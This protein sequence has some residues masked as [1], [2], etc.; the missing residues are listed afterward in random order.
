[1]DLDNNQIRFEPCANE[2][3]ARNFILS[4]PITKDLYEYFKPF[5]Y[6]DFERG[7]PLLGE[8]YVWGRKDKKK[9]KPLLILQGKIGQPHLKVIAD[10]DVFHKQYP[11]KGYPLFEDWVDCQLRKFQSCII[12]GGCPPLCKTKAITLLNDEYR[13]DSNKCVGCMECIAHYDKGCLVTK[14]TQTRRT[15]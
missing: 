6:L 5:G 9:E 14:V 10:P 4:R 11:G 3:Y 1:L 13:I 7:R 15:S 8:V 2:T 12:C